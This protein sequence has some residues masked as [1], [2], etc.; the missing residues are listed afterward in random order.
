MS[1]NIKRRK[2]IKLG[3]LFLA[4][5]MVSSCAP[6]IIGI[7]RILLAINT[8]VYLLE[9]S[10]KLSN[11]TA[12]SMNVSYQQLGNFL[13]KNHFSLEVVENMERRYTYLSNSADNLRSKLNE[14]DSAAK[15]MFGLIKSR[16]KQNKTSDLRKQ[17][18]SDI[19][20]KKKTFQSYL[21]AIILAI[22][23][24]NDNVQGV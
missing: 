17:M 9:L 8:V 22:T 15:E 3:G 7:R 18:I 11:D 1:V 12:Y 6:Q 21:C 2:F 10:E 5:T 20:Q 16:A 13:N 14:T 4:S 23:Q 19:N 24:I